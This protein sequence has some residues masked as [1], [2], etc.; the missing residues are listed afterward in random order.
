MFSS[1]LPALCSRRLSAFPAIHSGVGACIVAFVIILSSPSMAETAAQ[2]QTQRRFPSVTVT[3]AEMA[4]VV[5][6]VSIAGSL[7]AR[8]EVLVNP[9]VNGF[10]IKTINVDVGDTV[11]A[12]DLLAIL[13]QKT[14]EAQLAQANAEVLK[15]KAAV[16]Q[17]SSQINSAKAGLVQAQA[18]LGRAKQL[19]SSGNTSQA[20]LDQ[21][22]AAEATASAGLAA[23][24]DGLAVA[25]AQLV[26][27]AA[28]QDLA[29]LNLERT[30]IKAPVSG[31]ISARVA[32]IGA[33]ATSGG[34]PM[35]RII[36]D[37]EIELEAE[38][39]ETALGTLAQGDEVK[40]TVAGLGEI[41][42]R[43]RLIPPTV[44][45]VTRLG[46][47]K[48]MLLAKANLRSGLFGSGWIVTEKRDAITVPV[49]AVLVDGTMSYVLTVADNK[50][51]RKPVVAGLIWKERREIVSGIDLGET[52]IA[53]A[54]AFFSDGDTIEPVFAGNIQ[55]GT[56]Q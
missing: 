6:Q 8:E 41:E 38:V 10:E 15:A 4:E 46:I 16:R 30:N 13:D 34:E 43:V 12:G 28:Q 50:V 56:K 27:M 42:G 52:V 29:E 1:H 2:E 40:L 51:V 39:I 11:R 47:V 9:Q 18:A 32:K 19:R 20:T 26:Q 37:G 23:A 14:L 33:I 44:D 48:V 5:G 49:A 3:R 36:R 35:F 45:P 24:E 7:V 55:N 31:V 54:G 53:K 25:E 17:A 21:A 22:I